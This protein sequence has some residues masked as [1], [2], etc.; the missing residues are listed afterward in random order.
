M[1]HI[2]TFVVIVLSLILFS[3]DNQEVTVKDKDE[4]SLTDVSEK[5]EL[6]FNST[7]LAI[8]VSRQIFEVNP[9]GQ[10]TIVGSRGTK[11]FFPK[12]CFE[13]ETTPLKVE[14]KEYYGVADM[15]LGGL[16]TSSYGK[17]IETDGMIYIQA[18]NSE[19]DIVKLNKTVTI[20]IQ[21]RKRKKDI[22]VFDGVQE[23]EAINWKLSQA[24]ISEF[25]HVCT[26]VDGTEI[27]I[28][29]EQNRYLF[30]TANLGW[31]NCDRFKK[32]EN[33]KNL[34]VSLSKN[35]QGAAYSLVFY[36]F[37]SILK[38]ILNDK[39]GQLEFKHVPIGAKVSLV[40]IGRKGEQLYFSFLDFEVGAK[41][42][43]MPELEAATAVEIRRV[44]E[45]KFG[46]TLSDRPIPL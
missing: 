33:T 31:I 19:G 35:Q 11:I 36:G 2:K 17:C 10:Q 23:N 25:G 38:G 18:T 6:I 5:E 40:G 44:M 21:T 41:E 24:K 29:F 43:S 46:N 12:D 8:D 9:K 42:V 16:S 32:F 22:L 13:G 39:T 26:T 1:T 7:N 15:V 27:D 28:A 20:E 3:C 30:E 37:N 45:M 34:I 4:S 14:L